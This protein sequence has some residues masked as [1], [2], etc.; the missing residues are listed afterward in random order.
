MPLV[1]S[2]ANSPAYGLGWSAASV[3]EVEELGGMVL[4]TPT[5][6]AY[7]GTSASI[8][9]N[10]SVTFNCTSLSLNGVF[11]SNYDNY[12]ISIRRKNQIG[13]YALRARLRQSGV[14]D[15]TTNSYASQVLYAYN[16]ANV[17]AS[18][19]TNNYAD[20]GNADAIENG[21]TLS[22]FGPYL[23]QPTALRSMTGSSELGPLIS[24]WVVTHN[25][26][27]SYDGIT[28]FPGFSSIIGLIA[29]YG[30]VGA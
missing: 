6:I 29:V 27:A 7:S 2:R 21:D 30:L 10:G 25:Q 3:P 16:N 22:V 26:S 23:A 17:A 20:I 18:R 5:S 12:L 11:N 13:D 28:I 24:N 15:Q 4:V 1:T 19:S 8:G 14:D 9:A